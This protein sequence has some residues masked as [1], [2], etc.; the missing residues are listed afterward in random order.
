MSRIV[1]LTKVQKKKLFGCGVGV[2]IVAYKVND[3]TICDF[4]FYLDKNNTMRFV[5]NGEPVVFDVQREEDGIISDSKTAEAQAPAVSQLP[6]NSDPLEVDQG[7]HQIFTWGYQGKTVPYLQGLL[8]D[9]H[10]VVLDARLSPVSRNPVW[11]KGNLEKVLGSRYIHVPAW[12]NLNYKGGVAPAGT[13]VLKD[14]EAG[15]GRLQEALTH[16][17][18][19][20]MCVCKDFTHCHRYTVATKLIELGYK[21]EEYFPPQPDKDEWAAPLLL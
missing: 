21:V 16:G 19:F 13:I 5:G 7:G 3:N 20:I 17:S 8:A 14:F 11:N 12:G 6:V 18:V 10:A 1:N 15:L 9:H 2:G 4:E